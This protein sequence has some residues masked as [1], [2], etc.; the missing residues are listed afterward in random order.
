MRKIVVYNP[1]GGSGKSTIVTNLAAHYA[2]LSRATAIVDLDPQGSSARWVNARSSE[3]PPIALVKGFERNDRVTRSWALRPPPGTE[4]V[5][6][7][8]PA[9]FD[10][11]ELASLTRDAQ[12]ILVPVLPSEIDIHAAANCV[13]EL[14][15]T[16]KIGLHENRIAV[17]ANR[18]RK[19]T[20][21]YRRLEAFLHSLGIPFVASLRDTQNYIDCA[22]E[23]IGID[24]LEPRSKRRKDI[25][26]WE[27]L[28]A[29][30]SRGNVVSLHEDDASRSRFVS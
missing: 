27:S 15:L 20:R 29:W 17:V 30:L 26:S 8:T 2:Q 7:D 19:N 16:A 24:E 18:V 1:K 11:L 13:R 14:L 21:I 9:A 12:S 6:V 25:E 28:H 23:G 4:E 3:H 10:R 5:I 22:C